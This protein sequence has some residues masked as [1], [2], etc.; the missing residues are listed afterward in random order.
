LFT[1]IGNLSNNSAGTTVNLDAWQELPLPVGG[2][3]TLANQALILADT[4]AIKLKTDKLPHSIKK[5]TALANYEFVLFDTNGD[6]MTTAIVTA[7]ISK[8]GAAYSP[9]ANSA[10]FVGEGTFKINLAIADT[11]CD[12]AMMKYTATGARPTYVFFVTEAT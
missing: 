7:E 3:A 2:D 11:T 9:M 10:T 4:N 8:D 6:P 12:T 5:A 1:G